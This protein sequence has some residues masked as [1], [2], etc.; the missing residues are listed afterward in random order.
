MFSSIQLPTS[1]YVPAEEEGCHVVFPCEDGVL[2]S[3]TQ[4]LPLKIVCCIGFYAIDF[5][6]FNNW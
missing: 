4:L 2:N 1:F 5:D 6:L 3:S